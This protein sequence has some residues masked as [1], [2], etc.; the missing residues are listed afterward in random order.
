MSII[1]SDITKLQG[2]KE[3]QVIQNL[4]EEL[5]EKYVEEIEISL[6]DLLEK[7]YFQNIDSLMKTISSNIK[8][9]LYFYFFIFIGKMIYRFDI[10]Y[11]PSQD[12]YKYR[13]DNYL[14]ENPDFKIEKDLNNVFSEFNLKETDKYPK[15]VLQLKS[16][17]R[18][19]YIESNSS[20]GN[21]SLS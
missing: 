3:S 16:Q 20:S 4:L 18:K 1:Q 7:N 5:E 12:E 10:L 14:L 15:I 19:M 9:K 21:I 8:D 13:I 17:D 11:N 6:I 2:E